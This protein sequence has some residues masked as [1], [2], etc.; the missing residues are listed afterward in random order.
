V[1]AIAVTEQV[2]GEETSVP[3]AA[4]VASLST[5]LRAMASSTVRVQLVAMAD[6]IVRVDWPAHIGLNGPGLTVAGDGAG[7][8]L[9]ELHQN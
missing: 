9:C 5:P 2:G 7:W 6:V 8:H 3:T 4:V 1:A